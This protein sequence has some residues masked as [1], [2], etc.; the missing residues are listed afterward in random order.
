MTEE[1][2]HV[3]TFENIP[4][5]R[6]LGGYQARKG[7]AIAPGRLYRSGALLD[8]TAADKARLKN[9][10]R[11]KTAI[12]VTTPHELKKTRE[13]RLLEE[14][15]VN[16]FNIPF[17]PDVPNYYEMEM[18]MYVNHSTMGAVYLERMRHPG[19][20]KKLIGAL[21]II[22]DPAYHPLVF[23]C[24]Q[25][26]DRTGILAAVVL[27]LIGVSDEDIIRDYNLSDSSA[28]EVRSKIVNDP[29]TRE[30]IRNLPDFCWRAVPESIEVFLAGVK[31]AYGS[32]A[33]YLKLHGADKTLTKR[34]E[35][36]LLV[37]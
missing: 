19:F 34:L 6:D 31:D 14:I 3:I 1:C 5:F 22:A 27:S 21:E 9:D 36:A 8:M 4:N 12:D 30:E 18:A 7:Q 11:L 25:G 23:H 29:S 32:P 2:S 17:R 35:K 37:T 33:G 28:E 13:I 10:I 26:K 24:S 20:G 16:Y 15:G